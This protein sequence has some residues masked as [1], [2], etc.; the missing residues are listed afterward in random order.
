[1]NANGTIDFSPA[2]DGSNIHEMLCFA[3][4]LESSW[5]NGNSSLF[6]IR[7]TH[8]FLTGLI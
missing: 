1:M 6:G 3:K 2:D 8:L 5:G 4:Y 7:V